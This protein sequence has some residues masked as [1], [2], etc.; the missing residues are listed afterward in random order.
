MSFG[1]AAAMWLAAACV[2][3]VVEATT[4]SAPTFDALVA[5]AGEVFLGQVTDRSS[6]FVV[7]GGKRLIVT[8]ITYRVDEA[9]KGTP[10]AIKV[11]TVLG[12]AVGEVRMDVAGMPAFLVGDRD[13]VFVRPGTPALTPIVAL[14]HGRFRVVTGP[15]GAGAFV[16]N[17]A[18]QP[19][20]TVSEYARPRRLGPGDTA[21]AL[22]QFL[23]AIRAIVAGRR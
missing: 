4:V 9:V 5:R 22:P 12:G 8:D 7:R 10:G 15:G 14:Y 13:I 20:Q 3:T 23:D 19:I 16:A 11:L 21:V 1:R 6:R 17:H 18:R 2:G